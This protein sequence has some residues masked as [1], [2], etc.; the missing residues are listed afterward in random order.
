M[1][2]VPPSIPENRSA[3]SAVRVHRM[4]VA[5]GAC[6][7]IVVALAAAAVLALLDAAVHLSGWVRGV[8]LAAWLTGIGVLVWR[9]VVRRLPPDAA[10]GPRVSPRQGLPG[11]LTAAA[12]ATLAL[13]GALLAATLVPGAGEHIRR[14]ALPWSRPAASQY[15][16]SVTSGDP[17]VRRG[18]TVTLS[19]YA[20][21][22]D[23]S[24]PA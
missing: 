7:V 20:D 11:N 3:D 5:R 16:V 23:P 24:A 22:I 14:V 15:R 2:A 12:A 10:D 1:S 19:A 18:D 8:S 9:L 21:K 4:R 17:V 13:A 6:W